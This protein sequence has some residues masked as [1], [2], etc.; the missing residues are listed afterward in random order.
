MLM[1]SSKFPPYAVLHFHTLSVNFILGD[2]I[3]R[4]M[5]A[6]TPNPGNARHPP[7]RVPG[8]P[9]LSP[10]SELVGSLHLD[11]INA[12]TNR[13]GAIVECLLLSRSRTPITGSALL[14]RA[15]DTLVNKSSESEEFPEFQIWDLFW[16]LHVIWHEGIAERRGIGQIL[17]SA[18][19]KSCPPGPVVK[20][21]FLG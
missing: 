7:D 16:V 18:V 21:V 3:S 6:S 15:N 19:Q 1:N 17:I 12:P 13:P 2:G 8:L 4:Q 10:T 9:L 20:A 11:S 5:D 14:T